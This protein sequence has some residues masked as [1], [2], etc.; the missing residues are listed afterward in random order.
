[1]NKNKISIIQPVERYRLNNGVT[2]LLEQLNEY[3]SSSAGFF[4][5]KGARDELANQGGYCHFCEHMIFKDTTSYT[6]DQIASIFDKMGGFINAYTSHEQVVLYNRVPPYYLMENLQMMYDMFQNST[7][8]QKEAELE[9]QVIIN[10]INSTLEDPSDKLHEDFMMNIFP[11]HSLGLPIIGTKEI[12]NNTLRDDLYRFYLDNFHADDLIISIAGN[13]DKDKVLKYL[14]S[15]RFR[16]GTK[17]KSSKA[18]AAKGGYHFTT[19]PSEQLH[20][21]AGNANFELDDAEYFRL[22]LLNTIF[23]ESMSSRLFQRVRE[24]LGLCYTIYSYIH[25]YRSEYLFAIYT[26][27]QPENVDIAMDAI[28]G[29]IRELLDKGISAE[30]LEKVKDQKVGS[31][32]LGSDVLQKR[33]SSNAYFE[34]RFKKSYKS[35][36]LIDI[37]RDTSLKHM[38]GLINKVFIKDNFVTHGLY[39]KKVK[40][41]KI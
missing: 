14:D 10:E 32:L 19:L 40:M 28:S 7:F 13:F 9:R 37:I 29:V 27:I 38:T 21:M 17:S 24:E 23:G 16:R 33:M 3:V 26:S 1:M 18:A 41:K 20:I 6:K 15:L 39:K 8:D 34:S 25:K 4:L 2:V 22:G 5:R 36:D 12:I 30:E 11:D 35:N 31:I